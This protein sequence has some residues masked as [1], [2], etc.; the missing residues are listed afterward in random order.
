MMQ[1]ANYHA[2]SEDKIK[3]LKPKWKPPCPY[4]NNP[5]SFVYDDVPKGHISQ[6][7]LRCGKVSI[8][9]IETMQVMLLPKDLAV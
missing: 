4:C 9:E 1:S 2:I 7:C 3:M 5:L 6:K 8:L